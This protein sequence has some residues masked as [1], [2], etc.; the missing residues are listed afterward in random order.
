MQGRGETLIISVMFC[1]MAYLGGF[2][3][4]DALIAVIPVGVVFAKK[5]RLDPITALAITLFGTMIGFG[6]GPTKTFVVQGLIGARPFGAFF[7]SLHHNERNHGDW[8]S[9]GAFLRQK[10]S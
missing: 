6:T 2:G 1:L 5:L 7:F 8:S 3:G 9:H 4:S 10:D